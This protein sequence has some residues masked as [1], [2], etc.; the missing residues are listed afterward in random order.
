MNM[1]FSLSDGK[2]AVLSGPWLHYT[3][4]ILE[5]QLRLEDNLDY[6]KVFF[7]EIID[8]MKMISRKMKQMRDVIFEQI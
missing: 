8:Y 3:L 7:F 6:M 1:S 5:V 4:V 2:L